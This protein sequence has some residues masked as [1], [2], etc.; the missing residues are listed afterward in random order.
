MSLNAAR[1]F[2]VT[3]FLFDDSDR[4]VIE[5]VMRSECSSGLRF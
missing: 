3:S 1:S 5:S 4:K 2:E